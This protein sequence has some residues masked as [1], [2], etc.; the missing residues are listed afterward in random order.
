MPGKLACFTKTPIG[1]L[2][3]F[4]PGK[5]LSLWNQSDNL[6]NHVEAQW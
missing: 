2:N 4:Q 6:F 1:Q 3:S 5:S